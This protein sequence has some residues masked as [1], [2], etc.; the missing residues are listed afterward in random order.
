M[1]RTNILC[2]LFFTTCITSAVPGITQEKTL[3]K[4]SRK[5]PE[6]LSS[7]EKGFIIVS[8]KDPDLE[9]ARKKS[10]DLVKQYMVEAVAVWV[11]SETIQHKTEENIDNKFSVIERFESK[12]QIE[13]AD[14]PS[15]HGISISKSSDSF[16]EKIRI[17]KDKSEY[18]IF[19]LKYPFPESELNLLVEQYKEYDNNLTKELEE[20]FISIPGTESVEV[21]EN[22]KEALHNLSV[23]FKDYRNEKAILGIQTIETIIDGLRFEVIELTTQILKFGLRSGE[24][25]LKTSAQPK[26]TSDCATIESLKYE[27]GYWIVEYDSEEC[28]IDEIN[29]LHLSLN[30]GGRLIKYDVLLDI[31]KTIVDISIKGEIQFNETINGITCSLYIQSEFETPFKID[32]ISLEW[33]KHQ[34]VFCNNINQKIEGHGLHQLK[35]KLEQDNMEEWQRCQK[36]YLCM[37]SGKI[38]YT[39]LNTNIKGSYNFNNVSYST[40]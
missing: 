17:K 32:Q 8:S 25:A 2:A 1:K 3:E 21:L 7:N 20:L 37:L 14:V 31:S 28:Y 22:K 27:N 23:V 4:S 16:W 36:K 13:S 6:W 29:S 35:L 11:E 38:W 40:K 30:S 18:Y 10:I 39:N 33:T 34:P 5:Q 19:Y 12:T 15:L 24:K 9:G 26:V